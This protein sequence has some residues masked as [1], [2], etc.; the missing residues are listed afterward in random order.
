MS[1]LKLTRPL[2]AY[3]LPFAVF[4]AALL[5]V[6]AVQWLGGENGPFWLKEPK[7]WIFPLQSI[8][9]IG[10]VIYFFR[11]YDWGSLRPV[12]IGALAGIVVLLIWIAP[13]AWLGIPPRTD[14]F[15]PDLFIESPTAYWTTVI[16]RFFR[17]AIVVPL[18]EEIFWRGFLMRYLIQEDF[19]KVPFGS[20]TFFSFSAVVVLFSA[21][22][23]VD[24]FA[25]AIIC[26]VIF[27]TVAVMTRS[28][29]ACVV[30]HAV[31]NF[32]LGLYVMNT[33]QWGFW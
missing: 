4:M 3:V 2:V 28:L 29:W 9:C 32:G 11:D 31:T 7:Y 33:K 13:Q 26:A 20:V 1:S 24:D 8:L 19:R 25:G 23:S 27:N 30:A 10:V 5:L 6:S 15:N 12:W 21:V 18:V 22:H 14:G 17:L 16:L